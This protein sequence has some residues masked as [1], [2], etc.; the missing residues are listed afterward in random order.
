VLFLRQRLGESFFGGRNDDSEG[1]HSLTVSRSKMNKSRTD[2]RIHRESNTGAAGTIPRNDNERRE[3]GVA[4]GQPAPEMSESDQVAAGPN[5]AA[6]IIP[7]MA[8]SKEH[9]DQDVI[10]I[11]N[12]T[13]VPLRKTLASPK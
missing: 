10:A 7:N 5:I 12:P 13:T 11:G 3:S 6:R 4:G 1:F 2:P 9:N 8:P